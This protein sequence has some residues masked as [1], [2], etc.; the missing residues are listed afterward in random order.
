MARSKGCTIAIIALAVI[1]LVI[2]VGL[3]LLWMN[4]DKLVDAAI[5]YVIETTEK[6]IVNNL[7]DGYTPEM[8]SQIMADLKTGLQNKTVSDAAIQELAGTFQ[9][10]MADKKID[11]EEGRH[12]LEMI[13][14]ALGREPMVPESVPPE[15]L[16]DSTAAVPDTA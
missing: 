10:A 15:Q 4:K 16:P 8:V 1:L 7:P 12:L 14:K 5:G 3:V 2:I 13:Q 11:K 6:E 9:A